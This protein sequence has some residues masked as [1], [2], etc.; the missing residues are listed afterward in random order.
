MNHLA[1]LLLVGWLTTLACGGGD[2]QRPMDMDDDDELSDAGPAIGSHDGGSTADATSAPMRFDASAARDSSVQTRD[3][4][5]EAP[6]DAQAASDA[7][8]ARDAAS[9]GMMMSDPSSGCGKA[10]A[11]AAGKFTQHTIRVG[12]QD[13]TYH[14]F[15]PE[16]YQPT[17][18]YPVIFRF[19]GTTGNGLSGGLDVQNVAAKDTIIVAPNGLPRQAGGE[20]TWQANEADLALFDALVSAAGERYCIDLGRMFAFGFSAGAGFSE[21]LACVRGNTLRGIG[22]IA[23]IDYARGRTCEGQVAAWLVH[24]A[25]DTAAPIAQGRSARDRILQQNG[26]GTETEPAG[27]TCVRYKGCADGHPVVW[28]ETQGMGHNIRGDYGPQEVWK[29]F[30]ALP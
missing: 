6:R 3:A 25:N 24:D 2:D 9:S 5:S 4:R 1:P 30:S 10:V 19:H 14:V 23:G 28:C 17:R 20:P 16:G 11:D 21:L 27:E 29:F 13:R 26:C 22:A 15:V 18:R 7:Q 12:N 8:A